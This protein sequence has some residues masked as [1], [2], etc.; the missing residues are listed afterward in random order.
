MMPTPFYGSTANPVD[1]TAQVVANPGPTRTCCVRS[2]TPRWCRCWPRSPGPARAPSNEALIALLPETDQA[3]RP[4]VDR[5]VGR[6]PGGR[7]CRPTPIPSGPCTPSGVLADLSLRQLDTAARGRWRPD[8]AR[9][10]AGRALLAPPRRAPG[11][12]R[13]DQQGRCLALYGIPVT[14]ERLVQSAE[15]A[16]AAAGG[17]RRPGGPQGHVLRAA[18]QDR[19]RGHPARAARRA[20]RS[21]RHTPRCWPRWPSG[22]PSGHRGG[23]GPGDGAGPH[24]AHLRHHRRPGLRARWSPSAWAGSWSRFCARR[25]CCARPSPCRR[26]PGDRRPDGRSADH[27]QPGPLGGR[28]GQGGPRHG[29]PRSTWPSSCHEVSE[30]DVNPI[31]VADDMVCAADALIGRDGAGMT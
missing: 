8:A 29:G 23:A 27:R 19:V 17:H 22:P 30:V 10:A 18:P 25:R 31:R 4:H 11:P 16:V 5:L 1:T 9:A 3:G 26:P 14:S 2:A 21:G 28:A 6:L 20:A 12:A 7:A 24:R 15:E 13:V